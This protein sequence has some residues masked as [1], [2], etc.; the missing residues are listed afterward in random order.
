MTETLWLA[1]A[2]L[3]SSPAVS[4]PWTVAPLP[5]MSVSSAWLSSCS[6][7]PA[8]YN[9]NCLL[10]QWTVY[11]TNATQCTLLTVP[12]LHSVYCSLYQWQYTLLTVSMMH[13]VHCLLCQRYTVYTVHCTNGTQCTLLTVPMIHHVHTAHSMNGTQC[14]LPIWTN[15]AFNNL[16]H[17]STEKLPCVYFLFQWLTLFC[18]V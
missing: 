12:N 2:L 15:I 17:K 10:C 8:L 3:W 16:D 6:C 7:G 9:V 4:P 13:I 5:L 18:P 1:V 11:C 14:P